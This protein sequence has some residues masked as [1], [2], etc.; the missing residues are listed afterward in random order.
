MG[1]KFDASILLKDKKFDLVSAEIS[2]DVSL[3]FNLLLTEQL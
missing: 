3:N 1:V 2:F